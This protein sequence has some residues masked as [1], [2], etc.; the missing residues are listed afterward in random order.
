MNAHSAASGAVSG[1]PA[2]SSQKNTRTQKASER[3]S[4]RTPKRAPKRATLKDI[5]KVAGV[6]ST[7]V[8]LV[9][10]NKPNRFT[11][12]TREQIRAIARELN[13]VPN[14]SARSLATKSSSLLALII[15]DIENLFFASLAKHMEAECKAAGYSLLIVDTGEDIVEQEQ[16]LQRMIQFGIDGLFI[17]PTY[18]SLEES[19]SLRARLLKTGFPV[20]FID[21]IPERIVDEAEDPALADTESN[22]RAFAYDHTR[23][24]QLAARAF[25]EQGHR[26]FGMIG[27][28]ERT[29]RDK[30]NNSARFEGF[31]TELQK[32]GVRVPP[33]RVKNGAFTVSA[34][35]DY[36]DELIDAGVT[37]VFC[38]NDLIAIGFTRRARERGLRVPE[39][40]SVIGYDDVMTSFGLDFEFTTVKQ[41]VSALARVSCEAMLQ[42]VGAGSGEVL[43][44]A[45]RMTLLMPELVE[46]T[47]VASARHA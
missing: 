34:G 18:S 30:G 40:I 1:S 44:A 43:S 25:L 42:A 15:P 31:L 11:E 46:R 16:A 7:A 4:E 9:L 20:M 29:G 27:P 45:Q 35:R 21:R 38:G 28:V 8:S 33:E 39:D 19:A 2:K 6:S 36:A 17:I 32:C 10:N 3:A 24:G 12:E 26:E 37:A 41:D 13:Y 47:T 14:Q 22:W 23:G 5:A